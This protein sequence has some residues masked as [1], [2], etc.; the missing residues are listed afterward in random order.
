MPIE[1]TSSGGPLTKK[2]RRTARINDSEAIQSVLDSLRGSAPFCELV[3]HWGDVC[4]EALKDD[5]IVADNHK[6]LEEVEARGFRHPDAQWYEAEIYHDA[7]MIE[8]IVYNGDIWI[9]L[10]S[11]IET[12]REGQRV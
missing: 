3:K 10:A 2:V 1:V 5:G 6:I 9:A 7:K 4:R 12:R 8:Q 11:C